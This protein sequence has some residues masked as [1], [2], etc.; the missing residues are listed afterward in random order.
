M[1][2]KSI[3][4]WKNNKLNESLTNEIK[5]GDI[6]KYVHKPH[7]EHSDEW[8]KYKILPYKWVVNKIQLPNGLMD[9]NTYL[10]VNRVDDETIKDVWRLSVTEL[11]N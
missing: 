3:K 1:I 2:H 6:V 4:S 11:D 10:Y 9:K 5:V 8:I 7:D